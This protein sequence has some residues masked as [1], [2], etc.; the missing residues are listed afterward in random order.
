[1]IRTTVCG[2]SVT[3]EL[4]LYTK[5]ARSLRPRSVWVGGSVSVCTV[6]CV[7]CGA[8]KRVLRTHT[9]GRTDGDETVFDLHQ[10]VYLQQQQQ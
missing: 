2:L 3:D 4:L 9:P 8:A 10:L 1:M 6:Q 5:L 7:G